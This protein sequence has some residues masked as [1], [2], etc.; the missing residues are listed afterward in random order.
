M[1]LQWNMERLESSREAVNWSHSHA[2]IKNLV[3]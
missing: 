3:S 2:E 1:F